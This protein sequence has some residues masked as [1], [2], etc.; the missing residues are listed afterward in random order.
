MTESTN[1]QYDYTIINKLLNDDTIKLIYESYIEDIDLNNSGDFRLINYITTKYIN[2]D[3]II[4]NNDYILT[5]TILN[6]YNNIN[7]NIIDFYYDNKSD[8]NTH[9]FFINSLILFLAEILYKKKDKLTTI[10]N[11]KFKDSNLL[12]NYLLTFFF[13]KI[14]IGYINI[15]LLLLN[16]AIINDNDLLNIYIKYIFNNDKNEKLPSFFTDKKFT[17]NYEIKEQ[18]FN[19]IDDIDNFNIYNL[20]NLNLLYSYNNKDKNLIL[21]DIDN[22]NN[23]FINILLNK[24]DIILINNN[25]I[26][27]II[28]NFIYQYLQ[29]GASNDS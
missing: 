28:F 9:Y 29:L 5:I 23:E 17:I 26:Y 11:K 22:Y 15:L 6:I 19:N 18:L 21:L 14:N 10:S 8:I 16:L 27:N 24:F 7:N 3:T 25:D 20:L 2:P 13:N 1:I 12:Y 4:Y